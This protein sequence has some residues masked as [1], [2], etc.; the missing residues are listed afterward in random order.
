MVARG[1]EWTVEI[2]EAC[3]GDGGGGGGSA[4]NSEQRLYGG[5]KISISIL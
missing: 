5:L 4:L 1:E 2:E 3:G